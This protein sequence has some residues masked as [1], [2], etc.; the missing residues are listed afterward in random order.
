MFFVLE[1]HGKPLEDPWGSMGTHGTPWGPYGVPVGRPWGAH[2]AP[3]GTHG[4]SKT[5]GAREYIHKLPINRPK[6]A[7][8]C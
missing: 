2:R 4:F 7:A 5:P 8:I 3:C 6:K 1:G